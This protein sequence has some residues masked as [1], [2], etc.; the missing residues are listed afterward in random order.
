MEV[1]KGAS[2][3]SPNK[4]YIVEITIGRRPI[5]SITV[6]ARDKDHAKEKAFV[7]LDFKV[8]HAYKS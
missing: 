4:D 8:K 6:R 5:G 1:P 7:Q 3:A 2:L